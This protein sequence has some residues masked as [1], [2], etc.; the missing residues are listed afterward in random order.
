MVICVT[1]TKFQSLTQFYS[2]EKT[3]GE[4]VLQVKPAGFLEKAAGDWLLKPTSS[5]VTLDMIGM[6]N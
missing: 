3:G 5:P 6:G 2:A 1:C 4:L